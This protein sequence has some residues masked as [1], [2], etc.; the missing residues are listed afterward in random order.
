MDIWAM[1]IELEVIGFCQFGPF[2]PAGVIMH[3][4]M[5]DSMAFLVHRMSGSWLLSIHPCAQSIFG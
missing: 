4:A 3:C 1:C 2:R 5:R